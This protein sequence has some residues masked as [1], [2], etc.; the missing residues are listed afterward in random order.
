[1]EVPW[2]L[3]FHENSASGNQWSHPDCTNPCARVY[4]RN[5]SGQ[6][7]CAALHTNFPTGA[8]Y[9]STLGSSPMQ[10]AGSVLRMMRMSC[11]HLLLVCVVSHQ[12]FTTGIRSALHECSMPFHACVSCAQTNIACQAWAGLAPDTGAR[13]GP[14][15]PDRALASFPL[16]RT[17]SQPDSSTR[18]RCS[19]SR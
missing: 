7:Q 1:M 2:N 5:V 8:L 13:T 10:D 18:A 11:V 14:R 4:S 16:C 19:S 15:A 12:F 6:T 9:S 3:E 17:G